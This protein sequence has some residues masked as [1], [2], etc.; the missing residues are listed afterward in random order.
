MKKNLIFRLFLPMVLFTLFHSCIHDETLASSDPASKEYT[1]KSLWKE[2][3]KYIK[4]VMKIYQD[5]EFEIK[6]NSGTPYWDYAT[7]VDR[8]DESFLMVPIVE[9]GK[10]LSVLKVPRHQD[11]VYFIYTSLDDDISFFQNLFSS[12]L[13][14]VMD[15]KTNDEASKLVCTTKVYSVWYPDNES[16]PD[17]SS[18]SGHWGTYHVTNCTFSQAEACLGV[19]GP[20]GECLEGGGGYNYPIGGGTNNNPPDPP[21]PCDKLKTQ[22]TDPNFKAKVDLLTSKVGMKKETGFAESKSGVF[23]QLSPS[24]STASSDGMAITVT[25]D[26]KGYIHN[27][28][29][30]YE[31]GNTNE[32]GEI[33]INQPIRM[34]SPADVNTLMTMAEM[35]TDSNYSELYGTMVS[36]YGNY[37]I[38]FTGTTS[39]IKTGFDTQRWRDEYIAFRTRNPYWSFEKLFLNFLQNEMNVQGIKLY[40][41]KSNGT[42]Q[43]KVLNSNNNVLSSDCP[44]S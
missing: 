39:D 2:D 4:N 20:N 18:G 22:N 1:N 40:K 26:L 25:P 42:I 9:N 11:K 32:N 6:K 14:K 34:F 17:P 43:E 29:N 36:S 44:Q 7:T 19:V 3:E 8:Y 28:L 30:D 27:H 41:I 31:T 38:M 24:A 37:T 10:V 16:N 21:N 35:V 33:E 15:A 5:N 13:K 12:K 23:T